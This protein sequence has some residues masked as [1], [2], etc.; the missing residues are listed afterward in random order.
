MG[1]KMKNIS[2]LNKWFLYQDSDKL[3]L[4]E[5]CRQKSYRSM[6]TRLIHSTNMGNDEFYS[7][8]SVQ[9]LAY[10][11][12]NNELLS[13]IRPYEI[14]EH[15]GQWFGDWSQAYFSSKTGAA[16]EFKLSEIYL[17]LN[18]KYRE[19]YFT[20]AQDNNLNTFIAL[21][22]DGNLE[23]FSRT[24]YNFDTKNGPSKDLLDT[25]SNTD[26]FKI[27]DC[28]IY[29]LELKKREDSG[30]GG[31]KQELKDKA[32]KI[33][34]SI[35]RNEIVWYYENKR[36]KLRDLLNKYGISHVKIGFG[37][38]YKKDGTLFPDD[39]TKRSNTHQKQ[40][41][42]EIKNMNFDNN[43]GVF[44]KVK[45]NIHN[46]GKLEILTPSEVEAQPIE[47]VVEYLYGNKPFY[48]FIGNEFKMD[49]IDISK[50]WIDFQ[51]TIEII[52]NERKISLNHTRF[53]NYNN[54]CK[55][56]IFLEKMDKKLL[57][58]GYLEIAN[59]ILRLGE[60]YNNDHI[61]NPFTL[62]KIDDVIN[63]IFLLINAEYLEI[64]NDAICVKLH[65]SK[66]DKQNPIDLSN[67]L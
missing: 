35:L 55:I 44:Q 53:K 52:K 61:E 40:L 49:L 21:N 23:R 2:T 20:L 6:I 62:D 33:I 56:I 47:I 64:K 29:F 39:Y 37:I 24:I 43:T 7:T 19:L 4:H 46:G 26:L 66:K 67:F 42:K 48:W 17:A 54:F 51:Y 41:Y 50:G 8:K 15:S 38:F 3:E 1:L 22:E 57:S 30:G 14:F 32:K 10:W 34:L 58:L 31:A 45:I 27:D 5:R 18:E 36:V 63:Y 28:E 59:E 9:E 25:S 11:Q 13:E 16:V 12:F 60:E 65:Y